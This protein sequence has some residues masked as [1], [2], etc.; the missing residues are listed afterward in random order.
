MNKHQ[1]CQ[2]LKNIKYQTML[3][4][5]KN[6]VLL[7]NITDDLSNCNLFNNINENDDNNL[8]IS[9]N[10]LD[11]SK[12]MKKINEY[13]EQI[14]K[15]YKLSQNEIETLKSYLSSIIDK[16]FLSRNRDVNYVKESGKLEDIPNLTFNNTT[17]KFNYKKNI[18][19]TSTSKSLGPTKKRKSKSNKKL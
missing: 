5:S 2:E 18:H 10:K 12:K 4:N 3:Q 14:S 7:K 17:R 9:W 19:T 1:E 15:K 8:N 6:N 11:K 13:I 16:K